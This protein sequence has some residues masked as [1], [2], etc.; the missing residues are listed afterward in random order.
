MARQ[1]VIGVLGGMGQLQP[2]L[3]FKTLFSRRQIFIVT[4]IILG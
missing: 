3:S 2:L 1:T 4:K